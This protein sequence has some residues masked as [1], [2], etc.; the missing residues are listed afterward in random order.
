MRTQIVL[1]FRRWVSGIGDDCMR[2]FPRTIEIQG[3]PSDPEFNQ[4]LDDALKREFE[5]QSGSNFDGILEGEIQVE[6]IDIISDENGDPDGTISKSI[7]DRFDAEQ[8]RRSE[9]RK[10]KRKRDDDA[11]ELREYRRL[12]EKFGPS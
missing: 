11:K 8:K 7:T 6:S 9:V 1:V 4:E 5:R 10:A 3:V 12:R 2:A